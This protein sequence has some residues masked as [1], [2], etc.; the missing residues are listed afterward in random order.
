MQRITECFELLFAGVS[1]E[2][3]WSF[4]LSNTELHRICGTDTRVIREGDDLL[5]KRITQRRRSTPMRQI[6]ELKL[7]YP[8]RV[9]LH[10]PSMKTAC[11][12]KYEDQIHPRKS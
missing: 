7:L 6:N 5:T 12:R 3:S 9:G 11:Q 10:M 4:V 2:K 8:E 1:D